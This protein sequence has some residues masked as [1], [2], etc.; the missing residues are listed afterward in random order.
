MQVI[1]H[2]GLET[3]GSFDRQQKRFGVVQLDVI[4][5]EARE[6]VGEV[7]QQSGLT[8]LC[9]RSSKRILS[10]A[11]TKTFVSAIFSPPLVS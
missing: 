3:S 8:T 9:A 6:C 5:S 4:A 11:M 2:F 7:I 1:G 10:L